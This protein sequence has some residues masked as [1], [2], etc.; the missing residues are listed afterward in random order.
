[1]I[2]FLKVYFNNSKWKNQLSTF[3]TGITAYMTQTWT[4]NK[5]PPAVVNV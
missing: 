5:A 4:R 3:P 2:L 1:M